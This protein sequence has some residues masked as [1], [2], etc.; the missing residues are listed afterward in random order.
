MPGLYK[1]PMLRRLYVHNFR[2]LENFELLV[3]ENPSLLLIGRNGAGKSTVGHA[4][5]ILQ[6]AARGVS[7]VGDL[8]G[9]PELNREELP[10]RIELDA[11]VEGHR[12]SYTLSLELPAN[13]RELRV[14]EE[15]LKIDNLEY[16][17]RTESFVQLTGAGDRDS[18]FRL[19]WHLVALPII[20]ERDQKDPFFF[21]RRWLARMLILAPVPSLMTGGSKGETLY[22][23]RD[24]SNYAEW[25]AGVLRQWPAAYTEI[26]RHAKEL[27]P[28]FL[29]LQNP[30]VGEDY[31]T[32]YV[33]FRKASATKRLA[34]RRLSDGEKC[35]FLCALVLA[36]NQVAGPLF[37]FWDEPD[38]HLSLSE[39][40]H[41]VMDLRK[42]FQPGGQLMVV[43]HN[44]EAIRQFSDSNTYVLWRASHLDPTQ[45]R[46]L[47][48]MDVTGD[49]IDALT[50]NEVLS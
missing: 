9:I 12:F 46:R 14:R 36:A 34:F 15:S 29:D 43:S 37:C 47:S 42:S 38:S 20:Q 16:F 39:V 3:D 27:M 44:P 40:G 24:L 26:S 18:R 32:I 30:E 35:F 7:R 1:A 8:V 50:R 21:F 6:L 45:V 25:L 22:P 31:K 49:L 11:D 28:D 2:C 4:L 13:F 19:D 10:F 48:E 33:T 5:E 17:S 23:E 41:F